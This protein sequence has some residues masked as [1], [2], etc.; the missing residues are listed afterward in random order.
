MPGRIRVGIHKQAFPTD[1]PSTILSSECAI[2][3]EISMVVSG[4]GACKRQCRLR[5][6]RHMRSSRLST[7]QRRTARRTE[8][9]A[10]SC[11]FSGQGLDTDCLR[12]LGRIR[13]RHVAPRPVT[14]FQLR[15]RH[16]HG[17]RI[18]DLSR[19]EARSFHG[20]RLREAVSLPNLR[21]TG[22]E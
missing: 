4:R 16:L 10:Q 1:T 3:C 8:S 13:H 19:P 6:C 21:D 18:D 20:D 7:R 22:T 12:P 9:E 5:G 15:G 14:F 11:R 17:A 2:P